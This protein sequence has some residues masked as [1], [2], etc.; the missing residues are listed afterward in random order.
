MCD[1]FTEFKGRVHKIAFTDSVHSI[2]S[3]RVTMKKK[4]WIIKVHNAYTE[5]AIY[6]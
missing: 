1:K 4:K 6:C 5:E 2:H 3:H